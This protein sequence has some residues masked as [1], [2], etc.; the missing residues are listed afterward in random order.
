LGLAEVPD[1]SLMLGSQ[2]IG[3]GV[4]SALAMVKKGQF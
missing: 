3:T 1:T 2:D 4:D